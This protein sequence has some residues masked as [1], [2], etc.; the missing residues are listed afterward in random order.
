MTSSPAADG[1]LLMTVARRAMIDNGLQ[2]DFGDA[3]WW[4]GKRSEVGASG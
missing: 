1:S 2:P 3:A 4:P